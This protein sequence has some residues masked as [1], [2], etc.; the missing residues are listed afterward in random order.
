LQKELRF[1]TIRNKQL[2]GEALTEED[3]SFLKS[4]ALFAV[5]R[6]TVKNLFY[7]VTRS[8]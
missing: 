8:K 5:I 4:D 7:A 2:T 3:W 6:A 1:Q